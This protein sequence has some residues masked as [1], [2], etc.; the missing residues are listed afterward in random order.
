MDVINNCNRFLQFE[1]VG[2]CRKKGRYTFE[3]LKETLL[4]ESAL[5]EKVLLEVLENGDVRDCLFVKEV[6]C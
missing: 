1:H 6:F 5:A 3:N 4:S 2:L